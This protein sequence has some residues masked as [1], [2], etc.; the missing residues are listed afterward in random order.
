MY[1]PSLWK[2]YYFDNMNFF[3]WPVNAV[4]DSNNISTIRVEYPDIVT[5]DYGSATFDLTSKPIWM[6]ASNFDDHLEGGPNNDQFEGLKGADYIDGKGGIDLAR[7]VHSSEAVQIGMDG[8]PG[9]GGDAEGDILVNVERL[10]G[11]NFD[12]TLWA[13][14]TGIVIG[15]RQGNDTIYGNDLDNQLYGDSSEFSKPWYEHGGNDTIYGYGGDDKIDGGT[16]DD[17]LDGGAGNDLIYGGG[18][19]DTIIG[20]PG[21]DRIQGDGDR[22]ADTFVFNFGDSGFGSANRDIVSG[23]TVGVDK[24][25]LSS[26]GPDLKVGITVTQYASIINIDADHNGS[27]DMQIQ[28]MNRSLSMHDLILA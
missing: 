21:K 23:F 27:F 12:D 28:V 15:G 1:P 19:K 4:T 6:I 7:Y 3:G 24:I 17:Y 20:G 22:Q 2:G 5:R 11:S 9:T 8:T 26:L 16:G 18:G 13:G 10:Q 14:T 25:D